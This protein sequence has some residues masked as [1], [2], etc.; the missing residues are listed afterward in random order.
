[1]KGAAELPWRRLKGGQQGFVA[2]LR[3]KIRE[4]LRTVRTAAAARIKRKTPSRAAQPSG[5][6]ASQAT[7]WPLLWRA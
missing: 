2:V 5:A 3:E 4:T 6:A 1:L 7:R